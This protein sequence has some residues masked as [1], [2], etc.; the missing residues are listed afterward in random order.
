MWEPKK[1]EEGGGGTWCMWRGDNYNENMLLMTATRARASE[2]SVSY[3][4]W[5]EIFLTLKTFFFFGFMSGMK[6]P[7]KIQYVFRY[8]FLNQHKT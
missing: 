8:G 4:E 7:V 5:R 1:K 3:K 2:Y 6:F